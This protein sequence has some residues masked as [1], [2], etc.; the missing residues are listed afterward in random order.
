[1]DLPQLTG[2]PD[3]VSP[4]NL[5][6]NHLLPSGSDFINC[7]RSHPMGIYKLDEW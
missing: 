4:D 1:L 6:V 5:L 7:H 2:T 3:L